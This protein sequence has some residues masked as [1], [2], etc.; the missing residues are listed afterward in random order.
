[1]GNTVQEISSDLT[2]PVRFEKLL[3][4]IEDCRTEMH[5]QSMPL[6]RTKV[7]YFISR[8]TTEAE[9]SKRGLVALLEICTIEINDSI[10]YSDYVPTEE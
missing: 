6:L 1:M 9:F 2:V 10:E 7:D 5:V 3:Y 8:L 4:E